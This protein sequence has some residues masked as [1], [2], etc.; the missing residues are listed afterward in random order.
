MA[1]SL[2]SKYSKRFYEMLS[3]YKDTR[4]MKVSINDL[5]HRL[6]FIDPKKKINIQNGL[7]LLPKF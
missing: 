1:L 3:Q 5:K 6:Q 4:M 7:C 2:K